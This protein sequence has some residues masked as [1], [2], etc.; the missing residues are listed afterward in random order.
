[1]GSPEP[2]DLSLLRQ[3]SW[4]TGARTPPL[5]PGPDAALELRLRRALPSTQAS[6][7]LPKQG[8][9]ARDMIACL[10][11]RGHTVF[12][13]SKRLSEWLTDDLR[14]RAGLVDGRGQ[15]RVKPYSVRDST[16]RAECFARTNDRARSVVARCRRVSSQQNVDYRFG[17]LQ[18][19]FLHTLEARRYLDLVLAVPPPQES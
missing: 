3:D 6:I 18:V 14:G 19:P 7:S 10:A 8:R 5:N 1:V 2:R 11:A 16:Y 13:T 4:I 15:H 17:A 12:Q 9:Y